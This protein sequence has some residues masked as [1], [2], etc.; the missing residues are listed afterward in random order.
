MEKS[1]AVK[2]RDKAARSG[3]R[4]HLPGACSQLYSLTV[5]EQ[6]RHLATER[7]RQTEIERREKEID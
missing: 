7:D 2:D 4:N 3:A 6:G 5:R 1:H